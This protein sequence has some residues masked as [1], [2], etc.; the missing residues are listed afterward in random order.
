MEKNK[1]G[2]LQKT[3]RSVRRL[4]HSINN[5]RIKANDPDFREFSLL[6]Y[7]EV[8]PEEVTDPKRLQYLKQLE[9]AKKGYTTKNLN[10]LLTSSRQK[11]RFIVNDHKTIPFGNIRVME[12]DDLVGEVQL[13]FDPVTD[14]F[15]T[16]YRS[17]E[18]IP[19][20][21]PYEENRLTNYFNVLHPRTDNR[22]QFIQRYSGTDNL[23]VKEEHQNA[24]HSFYNNIVKQAFHSNSYLKNSILLPSEDV[25]LNPANYLGK[26]FYLPIENGKEDILTLTEANDRYLV[27]QSFLKTVPKPECIYF[28]HQEFKERFLDSG[29]E[30][31]AI[32]K[33]GLRL[34]VQN[35]VL[36]IGKTDGVGGKKHMKWENFESRL[37][38]NALTAKEKYYLAKQVISKKNFL[39]ESESIVLKSNTR[40]AQLKKHYGTGLWHFAESSAGQ[41]EM[42]FRPVDDGVLLHINKIYAHSK[43]FRTAVKQIKNNTEV[44][45]LTM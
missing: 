34:G 2:R 37:H 7:A 26:Q 13:G 33:H 27:F 39:M 5:Y 36:H 18:N 24:I 23:D 25:L 41:K 29:I 9:L 3:L 1:I 31:L 22:L 45:T 40:E 14:T 11:E 28:D 30:L 4:Y 19:L 20:W 43:N 32:L 8:S 17:H 12:R 44:Q 42:N 35:G 16:A 15:C 6:D 38:S 10:S 21:K